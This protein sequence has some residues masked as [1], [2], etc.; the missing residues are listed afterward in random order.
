MRC[1]PRWIRLYAGRYVLTFVFATRA[2]VAYCQVVIPVVFAKHKL[3][4]T[5]V[6]SMIRTARLSSEHEAH[7][8][9]LAFARIFDG[10]TGSKTFD[11]LTY[12]ELILLNV[13]RLRKVSRYR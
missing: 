1:C 12:L 9:G 11:G 10:Y 6:T 13:K 2:G 5:F 4:M 7:F 8:V 3:G